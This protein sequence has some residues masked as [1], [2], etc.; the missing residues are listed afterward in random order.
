[1]NATSP[2]PRPAVGKPVTRGSRMG[3]WWLQDMTRLNKTDDAARAQRPITGG[4][5][6]PG[7]A[8]TH[9]KVEMIRNRTIFHIFDAGDAVDRS[10]PQRQEQ[11]AGLLGRQACW[12]AGALESTGR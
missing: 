8:H 3:W 11:A 5:T 4:E 7:D 6:D 1:M 9:S 12:S 2:G 10:N